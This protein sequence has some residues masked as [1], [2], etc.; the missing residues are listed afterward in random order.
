MLCVQLVNLTLLEVT[1]KRLV[2]AVNPSTWIIPIDDVQE[3]EAAMVWYVWNQITSVQCSCAFG[4]AKPSKCI[5]FYCEQILC[6]KCCR[7]T[8]SKVLQRT[9]QGGRSQSAKVGGRIA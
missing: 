3:G 8:L 6:V 9:S 2:G 1:I 7:R 4:M 5:L